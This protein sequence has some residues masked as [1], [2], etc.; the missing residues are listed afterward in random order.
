M[1]SSSLPGQSIFLRGKV[2]MISNFS[3]LFDPAF[4]IV[5]RDRDK[6]MHPLVPPTVVHAQ[7]MRDDV[8]EISAW[9]CPH[10]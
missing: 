10:S 2:V 8:F 9:P 3:N 5:V 4:R 7:V 6:P 1:V